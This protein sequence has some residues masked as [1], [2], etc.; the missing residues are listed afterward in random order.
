[1]MICVILSFRDNCL[2]IGGKEGNTAER[3]SMPFALHG[4]VLP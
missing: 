4:P 3:L 1:V 2:N